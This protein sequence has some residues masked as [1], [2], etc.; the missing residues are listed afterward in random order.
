MSVSHFL[1]RILVVLLCALAPL[2]GHAAHPLITEDTG[3][4]G[5]GHFQLELTSEHATLRES[6]TNQLSALTTTAFSYG[7]VNN[8]DVILTLPY[9]RLGHTVTNDTPGASGLA[10]IGLDVKWR[11]YEKDKLSFAL[12]PGITIPTG[13]DTRNLGTGRYTWS[14]YLTASYETAPWTWLLHLGHV[15]HNNT[16]SE[17]VDIWHASAAVVRHLGDSLKFILDTG[18]DTNTNHDAKSDP[19][20]LITGFIYSPRQNF[21]LDVGY[22]LESADSWRAR[23]LLAGL[24]LRW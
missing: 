16:F 18:I 3:T 10:D 21:D 8:A 23:T 11:F 1:L 13:D 22:K 12:K 4:Q 14:A 19:L 7:A 9:L 15:H 17:R 5:Q 20:F 2:S 24:T 6:G